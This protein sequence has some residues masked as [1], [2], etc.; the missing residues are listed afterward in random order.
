MA[1]K[2]RLQKIRRDGS[3]VYRH[4]GF[5]RP[6]TVS[7][8]CARNELFASAGFAGDQHIHLGARQSADD[9][10]DGLHGR[11]CT[12]DLAVFLIGG[13]LHFD[14]RFFLKRPAHQRYGLLQVERLGKIL[15][16][17]ALISRHGAVE[18]GIR[19]HHDDGKTGHVFAEHVEQFQPAGTRH[20]NVGH[21]DVRLFASDTLQHVIRAVKQCDRKPC[22][23]QRFL[24]H[25]ADR[26]IIIY[27]PDGGFS[28]H[29]F[30][31][32]GSNRVKE[33]WPGSLMQ[34]IRPP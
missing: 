21:N 8:N 3:S 11:S 29:A 33:V 25:P 2:L 30:S 17:P 12:Y 15:K 34:V 9:P 31:S 5:R 4:K 24:K 7:I 19:G 16:C 32:T 20:A 26:G 18:I 23:G 13:D 6:Q 27:Y 10:K 14:L 28:S 1:E 22:V